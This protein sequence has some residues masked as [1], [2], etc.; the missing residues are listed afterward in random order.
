MSP[1]QNTTVQDSVIREGEID[2]FELLGG[3]WTQ[4]AVIIICTVVVTTLAAAFAF[5]S[6]PAYEARASLMPPRQSDIAGYNLGLSGEDLKKFDVDSVYEALKRNLLS[7]ALRREFF[8]NTYLPSLGGGVEISSRDAQ[9]EAFNKM[10]S[11]KLS[12]EKNNSDLFLVT[13]QHQDPGVAADWVN[14]YVEMGERKTKVEL[15]NNLQAVIATK[16][17]PIQ[18]EIN[19]LRPSAKTRR[20]DRIVRLRE[21]LQVAEAVGLDAPQVTTGRTSSDGDLAEFMDGN[22]MYMRGAK[23]IRSELAILEARKNDDPF[24]PELR[25]L[26]IQLQLLKSREFNP[27]SVSVFTLDSAAEAPQRPVK[28]KK[29]LIIAL[30]IFFGGVFGV[31]LALTRVAFFRRKV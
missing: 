30:G 15:Q 24:I 11:A 12:G 21:A 10:I 19:L 29:A 5:F 7:E 31:F 20:E 16:A 25:S 23:A 1:V 6:Q 8:E 3:I 27:G 9:W 4:K 26:E 14:L 2:L 17:K 13:V 22:L 18:L 28:P